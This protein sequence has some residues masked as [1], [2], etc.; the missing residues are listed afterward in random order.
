MNVM[1]AYGYDVQSRTMFLAKPPDMIYGTFAPSSLIGDLFEPDHQLLEFYHAIRACERVAPSRAT[2]RVPTPP[3]GSH[4][5]GCP[6][7]RGA[8][9]SAISQDPALASVTIIPAPARRAKRPHHYAHYH[10][11]RTQG[12]P[13]P[14]WQDHAIS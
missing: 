14:A 1:P 4:P 6:G 3:Q 12:L 10:A 9:R 2:T 11:Q 5:C 8:A 13:A 7:R